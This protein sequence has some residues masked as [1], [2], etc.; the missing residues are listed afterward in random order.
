MLSAGPCSGRLLRTSQIE[1]G[2]RIPRRIHAVRVCHKDPL[3]RTCQPVTSCQ[4]SELTGFASSF[5]LSLKFLSLTFLLH[6]SSLQAVFTHLRGYSHYFAAAKLCCCRRY[7][8][9]ALF[10]AEHR[11]SVNNKHKLERYWQPETGYYVAS[12]YA[13]IKYLPAPVLAFMPQDGAS[14][15]SAAAYVGSG[16]VH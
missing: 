12:V 4:R 9:S 14:D 6:D 16:Q 10:S 8:A 5:F 11:S 1:R 7:T 13:P 15:Y 2:N 3:L